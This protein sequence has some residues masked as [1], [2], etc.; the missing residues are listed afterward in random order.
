MVSFDLCSISML[1]EDIV[2]DERA[3][4][5]EGI[6]SWIFINRG[7]Y[8]GNRV[9][10]VNGAFFFCVDLSVPLE[11]VAYFPAVSQS[12]SSVWL[13]FGVF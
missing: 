4:W 2:E 13:V 6:I 5:T 1:I 7:S 3:L 9:Q 12:V 10:V 11:G 8:H